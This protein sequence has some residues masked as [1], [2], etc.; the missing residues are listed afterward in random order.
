[1]SS[2]ET[3][4]LTASDGATNDTFGWSLS[5]DAQIS[6]ISY[7]PPFLTVAAGAPSAFVSTSPGAEYVFTGYALSSKASL[8]RS[9]S[10]R[11]TECK[12]H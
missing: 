7:K 2:T 1:M 10:F 9:F 8:K 6:P 4:K 3:A 5:I 12:T 11:I